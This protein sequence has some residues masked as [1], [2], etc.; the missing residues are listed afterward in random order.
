VLAQAMTWGDRMATQVIEVEGGDWLD[1]HRTCDRR[2]HRVLKIEA[3]PEG[4][5]EVDLPERTDVLRALMDELAAEGE[6]IAITGS[7][8]S[9]SDLFASPATRIDTAMDQVVWDIAPEFLAEDFTGNPDHFILATGGAKLSFVMNCL[10]DKRLSLRTAGSHKGQSIAGA[11]GTGT[12]GSIIGE[13]G[14]ESHVRALLFVNGTGAVHWIA[15]PDCPVLS[16][17]FVATFAKPADP[18]LFHDAT[19]HLG[20]LGYLAAVL[21]EGVPRFGLSWKKALQPLPSDW[22]EH[23]ASA[24]YASAA[25]PV[26]G[27]RLP[28]FYEVTFDPNR[29]V[30]GEVMQTVYW[31]DDLSADYNEGDGPPKEPGTRDALDIIAGAINAFSARMIENHAERDDGVGDDNDG[32][33]SFAR[34]LRLLDI[35]DMTFDDFRKEVAENPVSMRPESLAAL[36]GEWKPRD[37]LGIRIDTFNAALAVPVSELARALEIGRAAASNWRKHFVFTVRF[38]VKSRASLSFLRFEDAAI[39]N[40]D[41]LTRAGIAGWIS[42]SDEFTRDFTNRLEQAGIAFS[43]HWGKDIPS[44]ATKVAADFGSAVTRYK[45]IRKALVPEA[46][47]AIL[48]PPM[49]D[50][51]GLAD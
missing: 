14:L 41:G 45:A 37:V 2:A 47:R 21:I 26:I 23:V 50:H 4:A 36:T 3:L 19:I 12:H 22:W 24:D 42:H 6:P 32:I 25:A 27:D 40:I 16:D 7:A 48:R 5:I 39:I 15:D 20:G 46:L 29:G 28:A 31:R 51:W 17:D 18:A 10:D 38:A 13:S 1:E 11:I 30:E 8:W 49:L 33:F 44:D 35:A 34:R 9:Q 43:M